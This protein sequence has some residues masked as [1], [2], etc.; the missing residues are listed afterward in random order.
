MKAGT[1]YTFPRVKCAKCGKTVAENWTVR[2]KCVM[3][4][5][6]RKPGTSGVG[7]AWDNW[8]DVEG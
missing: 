3:S 4:G 1:K 8:E 2:H 6:S 7:K 5:R